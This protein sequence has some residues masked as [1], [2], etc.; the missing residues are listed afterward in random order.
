MAAG[1]INYEGGF[2][3]TARLSWFC[4]L[5][6]FKF[7]DAWSALPW[8]RGVGGVGYLS[9]LLAMLLSCRTQIASVLFALMQAT[10]RPRS[11]R[12]PSWRFGWKL[13]FEENGC[14]PFCAQHSEVLRGSFHGSHREKVTEMRTK[15]SV[16]QV[17]NEQN[18][19]QNPGDITEE[20]KIPL[21]P[22]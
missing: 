5:L 8:G 1:G 20:I 14:P 15:R 17:S 6:Q 4:R 21:S 9:H 13:W 7:Y 22:D 10:P 16:Q 12:S 18:E 2:G 19:P 3:Q 11:A